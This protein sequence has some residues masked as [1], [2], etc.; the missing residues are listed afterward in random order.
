MNVLELAETRMEPTRAGPVISHPE[1]NCVR[2]QP[3]PDSCIHCWEAGSGGRAGVRPELRLVPE[4]QG[5]LGCKG[6]G[7]RKKEQQKTVPVMF[8]VNVAVIR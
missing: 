8:H 5:M 6:K 7:R 4:I 3:G 1:V 2:P